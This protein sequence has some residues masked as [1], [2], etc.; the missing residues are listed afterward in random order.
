MELR[1]HLQAFFAETGKGVILLQWSYTLHLG[2]ATPQ[3]AHTK[4]QG[5]ETGSAG[6]SHPPVIKKQ[7]A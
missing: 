1:W 7:E 3:F 4:Q 6:I 5:V 2:M